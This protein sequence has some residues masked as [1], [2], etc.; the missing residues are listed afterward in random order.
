MLG[1]TNRTRLLLF[2]LSIFAC[3]ALLPGCSYDPREPVYDTRAN[4]KGFPQKA[5]DMLDGIEAGRLKTYDAITN[6][7][8]DIYMAHPGLLGSKDWEQV[9]RRLGARLVYRAD[10]LVSDGLLQYGQAAEFYRVAAEIRRREDSALEYKATQF[11]TW[12][13]FASDSLFDPHRLQGEFD[14][15]Y[16][17]DLLTRF[18]LADSLHH[19]FARDYL[20][21][22]LFPESGA[23]LVSLVAN[24]PAADL[25]LLASV[26]DYPGD[27]LAAQ[28][29]F[30]G[31]SIELVA[32]RLTPLAD[33]VYRFEAYFRTDRPIDRKLG[34]S[35]RVETPD[36]NLRADQQPVFPYD[37]EPLSGSDGWTAGQI[38]VATRTFAFAWPISAVRI[39]LYETGPTGPVE[40]QPDNTVGRRMRFP[41][42]DGN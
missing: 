10:R 42:T 40:L 39:G 28:G 14:T 22:E 19:A 41:V 20:A 17:M 5:I 24:R 18:A 1:S 6:G 27:S 33:T 11:E 15:D 34:I 4:P 29:S 37:F 3:G 16:R 21:P 7:F 30:V 8:A 2:M 26:S 12:S 36:P 38:A 23:D 13:E 31:R 35:L 32:W 9:V 25:A